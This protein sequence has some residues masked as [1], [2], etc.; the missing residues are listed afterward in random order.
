MRRVENE[1]IDAIIR[2]GDVGEAVRNLAG[3]CRG[4]VDYVLLR[5]FLACSQEIKNGWSCS[6]FGRFDSSGRY[7][8]MFM[9]IKLYLRRIEFELGEPEIRDV[10]RFFE[11]DRI[12]PY[13]IYDIMHVNMADEEE[14]RE[15]FSRC[16]FIMVTDEGYKKEFAE[17]A[18][19]VEIY[20]IPID[21]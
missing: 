21:E 11:K 13:I 19:K 3:D 9:K 1:R 20:D 14:M 4:I 17:H 16:F 2:M 8:D 6:L 7:Y 10:F 5:I 18:G 12:S 15:K